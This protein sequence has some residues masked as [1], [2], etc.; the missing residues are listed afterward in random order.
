MR[1][2]NQCKQSKSDDDFYFNKNFNCYNNKCKLCHS[3]NYKNKIKSKVKM[4][5]PNIK[6]EIKPVGNNY[7]EINEEQYRCAVCGSIH[8]SVHEGISIHHYPV[9]WLPKKS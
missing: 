1:I 2:C 4:V 6:S 3:F 5:T 8:H 9:N 7:T